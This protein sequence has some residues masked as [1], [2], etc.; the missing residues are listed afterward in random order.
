MQLVYR[1]ASY[2]FQPV[3]PA[4]SPTPIAAHSLPKTNTLHTLL[5]RGQAYHSRKSTA[6][7]A[8]ISHTLNWRFSSVCNPQNSP[9]KTA[10]A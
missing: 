10:H 9:L 2:T 3:A 8:P 5:Y 7:S 6:P 1:A 4:L